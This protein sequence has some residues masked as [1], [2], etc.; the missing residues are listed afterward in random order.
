VDS[1]E[2]A[3]CQKKLFGGHERTTYPQAVGL[4]RWRRS[5]LLPDT[6][7]PF[8]SLL[9]PHDCSKIV[10]E[11][12][13]ALAPAAPGEKGGLFLRVRC[14]KDKLIL[15]SSAEW[16]GFSANLPSGGSDLADLLL[17]GQSSG[18]GEVS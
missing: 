7:L 5:I 9:H 15:A 17:H 3:G 12:S 18:E 10:I 6:H 14:P 13:R 4:E 16:T 11:A 2:P 8:V 1:R